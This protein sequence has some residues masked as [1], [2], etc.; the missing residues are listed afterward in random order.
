MDS[1]DSEFGL[2]GI[3]KVDEVK[4]VWPSGHI[5]L[6]TDVSVNQVMLVDESAK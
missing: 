2:A 5:Q 6:F 1:I 4:I 3:S